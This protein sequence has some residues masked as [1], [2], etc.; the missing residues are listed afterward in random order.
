MKFLDDLNNVSAFKVAE[1]LGW[2]G[3]AEVLSITLASFYERSLHAFE[4]IFYPV[5]AWIIL[6]FVQRKF[7]KWFPK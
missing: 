1:S 3:G 5:I 4:V 6:F 7:K 2:L